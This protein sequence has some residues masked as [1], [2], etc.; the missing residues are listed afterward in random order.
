ME[1][2][3]AGDI[4]ERDIYSAESFSGAARAQLAAYPLSE[5]LDLIKLAYQSEFG[6]GHLINDGQSALD[7]LTTE[8]E[9]ASHT[10]KKTPEPIGG[11]LTR[12]HL[13]EGYDIPAASEIL[14]KL[15]SLTAAGKKG[16]G[17]GLKQKLGVLSRLGIPGMDEAIREYEAAGCPAV[18]HSIA[19][20]Q[21]YEPHYR[22]I[23]SDFA[24]FF[25][26]LYAM[27]MICSDKKY[28]VVSVDGRCGSGKTSFAALA[29]KILGGNVFH[30]DDFYL[31]VSSRSEDWGSTPAG[32]M[33]LTRLKDEVILPAKAGKTIE[34]RRF[35]C[36]DGSFTEP[37][38]LPP[39][40]LTLIE[41]S[42]CQHPELAGLYDLK[43]F[44]TVS[45]REQE[46]RL[47]QREGDHFTAFRDRWIPMENRYFSAFDI[48]GKADITVDTT[49]LFDAI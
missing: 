17:S 27:R 30:T 36:H 40:A 2:G 45:S 10:P 28:A 20:A 29:Q 48:P 12:F 23:R 42:Y 16:S 3:T 19:F 41:G 44:L 35:R 6:P 14:V 34:L 33:D 9:A 31:P 5:P 11:G 1:I 13:T 15:F 39:A 37:E 43:I 22:V 32:N 47:R 49:G 7:R 24:A 38:E 25:P 26:A 21:A 18:H 4:P 8:W 46:K